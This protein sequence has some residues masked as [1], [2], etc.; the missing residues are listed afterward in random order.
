MVLGVSVVLVLSSVIKRTT[1]SLN[2]PWFQHSDQ[3]ILIFNSACA[4]AFV[5]I[6]FSGSSQR[7]RCRRGR[8]EIPHFSSK[9]QLC[10][11]CSR[12]RRKKAKKSAKRGDSRKKERRKAPKKS[13]EKGEIPSSPIYTNPLKNLAFV[14]HPVRLGF[15]PTY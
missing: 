14:L 15:C 2:H 12:I 4:R 7:G 5:C 8:I 1:P 11:P 10:A 6:C 13:E 3:M 9:L